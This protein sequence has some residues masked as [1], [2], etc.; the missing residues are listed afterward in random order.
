MISLHTQHIMMY[1]PFIN[2]LILFVWLFNYHNSERRLKVFGKSLIIIFCVTIPMGVLHI[3]FSKIFAEFSIVL[4]VSNYL[5]IY[6]IPFVLGYALIKYQEK[7]LN[8]EK[9]EGT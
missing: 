5:F 8:F 7:V 1:L 3:L 6:L 4:T 9:P 2:A